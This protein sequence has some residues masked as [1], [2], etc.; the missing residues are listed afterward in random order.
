MSVANSG[1]D[2]GK[3]MDLESLLLSL[4]DSALCHPCE[5]CWRIN[6]EGTGVVG[7][8]IVDA[9]LFA[10]AANYIFLRKMK[11]NAFFP[12][13]LFSSSPLPP[14]SIGLEK[15]RDYREVAMVAFDGEEIS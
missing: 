15:C 4:S 11:V 8:K 6:R 5:M 10:S 13:S 3:S 1:L 2:I 7:A 14:S 12:L 9:L